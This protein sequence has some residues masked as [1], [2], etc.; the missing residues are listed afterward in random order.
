M[1]TF[2]VFL[3]VFSFV[4]LLK[5]AMTDLPLCWFLGSGLCVVLWLYLTANVFVAGHQTGTFVVMITLFS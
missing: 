3:L 4:C 5:K 1:L 2:V